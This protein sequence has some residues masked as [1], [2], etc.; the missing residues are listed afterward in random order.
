MKKLITYFR[1]IR[2]FEINV[3]AGAPFLAMLI[4]LPAI[5]TAH[6]QRIA[7]A[8]IAF[9]FGWAHGY[10]M[11]EWGGYTGDVY[12]PSKLKRPLLAGKISPREILTFSLVCAGICV[13]LYY[14][15]D[16]K[17]L[18]IVWLSLCIGLLYNHPRINV[19]KVPFASFFVLFAVSVNDTLLGWL[20]FSSTLHQGFLLG[21]FF[22]LLGL[23]GICYHEAGD[24]ESDLKAGI[25]TNAVRFMFYT[26][27]CLYFILLTTI[28]IVPG[29]LFLGFLITYPV[30]L[31]FIFQCIKSSISTPTMHRF[32]KQYRVLYGVIG[33]YMAVCLIA[34]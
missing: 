7:H 33:L 22:G 10:T 28:H 23:A 11:N 9:F 5:N 1:S 21:T 31:Y 17:L 13:I 20:V 29:Y 12:D 3:R 27:S 19:K 34:A 4:T 16:P 15:L 8:L 24:Y 26:A 18:V 25:E 14:L 2:W 30:Y 32:I 6:I